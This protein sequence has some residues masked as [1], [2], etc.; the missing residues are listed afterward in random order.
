MGIYPAY[1][2]VDI[3]LPLPASCKQIQF[4]HLWPCIFVYLSVVWV[5]NAI[6]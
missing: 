5:V 4:Q 1:T 2:I 6:F 3:K